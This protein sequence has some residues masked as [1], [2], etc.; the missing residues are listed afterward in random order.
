[1]PLT[2][3]KKRAISMPKKTPALATRVTVSLETECVFINENN[4]LLLTGRHGKQNFT[5]KSLVLA[6]KIYLYASIV[7]NNGFM[8]KVT[9]ILKDLFKCEVSYIY[10]S[11]WLRYLH[12]LVI[13]DNCD[14]NKEF[15]FDDSVHTLADVA[16]SP[17][18]KHIICADTTPV[19]LSQQLTNFII[20][21]IGSELPVYSLRDIKTLVRQG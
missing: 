11:Q 8:I 20:E 18:V 6:I 7:S 14:G 16:N 9:Q 4:Q 13:I 17:I 19:T 15:T 2:R 10:R 5:I 12:N 3:Q 1:M 21:T